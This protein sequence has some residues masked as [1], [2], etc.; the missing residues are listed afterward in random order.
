M[1]LKKK[2]Q[3]LRILIETIS[4]HNLLLKKYNRREKV[5]TQMKWE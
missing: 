3:Q 4:F 5:P 2:F 1:K